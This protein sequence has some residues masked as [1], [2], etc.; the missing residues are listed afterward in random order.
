M[1]GVDVALEGVRD[2]ADENA[3]AVDVEKV[4]AFGVGAEDAEGATGRSG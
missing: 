1:F 2:V 3:V 4:F